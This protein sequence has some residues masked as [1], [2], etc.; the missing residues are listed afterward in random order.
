MADIHYNCSDFFKLLFKPKSKEESTA[1][2]GG[3]HDDLSDGHSIKLIDNEGRIV[4][5]FNSIESLTD[6]IKQMRS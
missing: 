3:L 4:G 2:E 5:G 6:F 1:F